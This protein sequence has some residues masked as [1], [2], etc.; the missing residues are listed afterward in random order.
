MQRLFK[1][2]WNVVLLAGLLSLTACSTFFKEKPYQETSGKRGWHPFLHPAQKKPDAQLLFAD[3]LLQAGR[4]KKAMKQYVA[5]TIYWPEAKEA[6]VAQ[7][8]YAKLWDKKGKEY[9]AFDEYQRLFNR[10]PGQFPYDEVLNRQFEIATN[11]MYKKKGKFLFFH[12]FSAPERAIPMFQAIMTNAPQWNKSAE[13]EYL[14][15]R[16]NELSLEYEAA[17]DNYMTVQNRYPGS[18]FAEAAS[19][20]TAYCYYLLSQES[21]NNEQ[22]LDAAWASMTLFLNYYPSSEKASLATEYRNT[23]YRA[24]AKIAYEKATY[25]DKIV[26]RPASALIAYQSMVRQFP[27]SDWTALAQIRIDALSNTV[28]RTQKD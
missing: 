7:Y 16:A 17:I 19:F 28:V 2:P 5:L 14:M 12:G 26:K 6:P 9:R 3:Q 11:L 13:T 24:R 23:L 22:I 18:T 10:Y 8:Q 21:P 1:Q 4:T 20:Q 27:H 15:G 25:Y